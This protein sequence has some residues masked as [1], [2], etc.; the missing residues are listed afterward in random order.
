MLQVVSED[1]I[2]DEFEGK[3]SSLRHTTVLM[4]LQMEISM[5]RTSVLTIR[6][7]I[8]TK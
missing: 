4:V 8:Q 2:D 1:T 5:M 6:I 3:K 7:P